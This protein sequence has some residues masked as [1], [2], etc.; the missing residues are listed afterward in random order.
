MGQPVD[1]TP[2]VFSLEVGVMLEKYGIAS[3]KR[4][5]EVWLILFENCT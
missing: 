5:G 1:Y 4:D 3:Q 2:L